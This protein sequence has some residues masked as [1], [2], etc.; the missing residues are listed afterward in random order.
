MSNYS[1]I[2]LVKKL[3]EIYGPTGFEYK[4][5]EFIKEQTEGLCEYI[6]DRMGNL[7]CLVKGGGEGYDSESPTK[8]MISAHMDEV[9]FIV[10]SIEEDGS[11]KFILDGGI[12]SKVLAG[13]SVVLFNEENT[14]KG[15]I[16]SKA[17]HSLSPEERKEAL[18]PDKLYINVGATNAEQVTA[19]ID[20][21]DYGTFDSDFVIFGENGKMMKSKAID[22]RLGCAAMIEIMRKLSEDGITLPYD[23]YF[24]FTVREEIGNSGAQTVAQTVRPHY[25]I[26][27]ETTAIADIAGVPKNSRVGEV[28]EGGV[29]S[30]MDR[31]TI[32][33]R[34]FV[35]LAFSVAK[36]QGI[37]AQVKRYVSGGNDAGHIHKSGSGVRSLA[38]SA[39]TRYLHSACCVAGC[40]DYFAIRDLVLAIIADNRLTK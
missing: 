12:D 10:Q 26:V 16:D 32:Y 22:D 37:K 21:G 20:V 28:G 8:I 15:V 36:E 9:G 14:V 3:C 40:D 6:P 4:V 33:D 30:L 13:R 25:A 27:L 19:L 11:V 23:V 24:A 29:I 7:V 5:A 18:T 1:G 34:D 38:I 17:I 31:S 39:P 35:D 2:E